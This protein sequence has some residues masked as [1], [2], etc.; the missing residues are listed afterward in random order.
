MPHKRTMKNNAYACA[1]RLVYSYQPKTKQNLK[2]FQTSKKILGQRMDSLTN[3][4]PSCINWCSL[5]TT[6]IIPKNKRRKRLW[7]VT[8]IKTSKMYLF[9]LL[10]GP[11]CSY[12][13][14]YA[15]HRSDSDA[16]NATQHVC[17]KGRKQEEW[18]EGMHWYCS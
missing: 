15:C 14:H 9:L 4:S 7:V 18:L 16:G 3:Q 1:I 12:L 13:L 8:M 2:H 17:L 5:W 10:S 11:M 6:N